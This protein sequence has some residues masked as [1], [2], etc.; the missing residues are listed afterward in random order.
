MNPRQRRGAV[1]LGVAVL[2]SA[3][4]FASV[5]R[6]V[7]SV[8]AEVGPKLSVLVVTKEVGAYQRP[9]PDAL[10]TRTMPRQWIPPSGILHRP[11][12]IGD[13]VAATRLRPGTYLVPDL[14]TAQ[15]DLRPG[16]RAITLQV[17]VDPNV[18]GRL[19][20]GALTDVYATFP[21]QG[22]RQAC[23]SRIVSRALVLQVGRRE[24]EHVAIMF[25]FDGRDSLKVTYAESFANRIRLALISEA[26]EPGELQLTPL[27]SAPVR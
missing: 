26:G 20:A 17:T 27:C 14:L 8:R 5:Y 22:K 13:R 18:T 1:L 3:F 24:G 2:G 9:G 25:A 21:A 23:A 6:Y 10:A 19:R 7:A 12:E 16:Q 11:E 4:V 15:P